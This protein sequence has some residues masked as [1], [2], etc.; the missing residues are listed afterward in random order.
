MVRWVSP[1]EWGE[2]P[3]VKRYNVSLILSKP[4]PAEGVTLYPLW[5]CMNHGYSCLIYLEHLE[6]LSRIILLVLEQH[7]VQ[8]LNILHETS[9]WEPSLTKNS[10]WLESMS[11][12]SVSYRTTRNGLKMQNLFQKNQSDSENHLSI[13]SAYRT[14]RRYTSATDAFWLLQLA[15]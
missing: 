6:I 12:N 5:Q 2:R 10:N 3:G 7:F 4:T 11:W 13:F 14:R 9:N 8:E 15:F 1:G